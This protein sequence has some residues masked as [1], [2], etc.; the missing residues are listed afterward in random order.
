MR[1]TLLEDCRRVV[2]HIRAK[3]LDYPVLYSLAAIAIVDVHHEEISASG[4]LHQ[5]SV[6]TRFDHP[7][8]LVRVRCCVA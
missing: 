7:G 3:C 4:H 6:R 1:A 5:I 8:Y 2:K